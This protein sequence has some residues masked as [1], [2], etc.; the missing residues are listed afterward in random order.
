MM[1][2]DTNYESQLAVDKLITIIIRLTF[3][4]TLYNLTYTA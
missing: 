1:I 2:C 3:W 4:P